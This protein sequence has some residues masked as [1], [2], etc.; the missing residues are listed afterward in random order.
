MTSKRFTPKSA[1]NLPGFTLMEVLIAMLIASGISLLALNLLGLVNR[2]V[3][4][5]S[6]RQIRLA[7]DPIVEKKLVDLASSV[8]VVAVDSAEGTLFFKFL[9]SDGS[10]MFHWSSSDTLI[11][12]G[13]D[14]YSGPVLLRAGR[15]ITGNPVRNSLG[16]FT[17]DRWIR[18][19]FEG[20][21][22]D[23]R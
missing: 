22:R 5:F 10:V 2:T 12:K 6:K 7:S 4:P 9:S 21:V 11:L 1:G 23:E 3:I 13:L 15:G 8:S 18:T 16:F 20:E 17:G 19:P 14:V